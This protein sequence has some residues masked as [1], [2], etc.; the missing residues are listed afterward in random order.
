[1]ELYFGCSSCK[2]TH[3]HEQGS[4][5]AITQYLTK[6]FQDI[7]VHK[8]SSRALEYIYFISK[9]AVGFVRNGVQNVGYRIARSKFWIR[10]DL[11]C[12]WQ[13]VSSFVLQVRLRGDLH[14]PTPTLS[15]L[16]LCRQYAWRPQLCGVCPRHMHPAGA[17]D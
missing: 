1:M 8:S 11:I 10:V 3:L 15:G 12:K 6:C 2:S 16:L 5:T 17:H 14:P 13:S 9:Q 7:G 4:L